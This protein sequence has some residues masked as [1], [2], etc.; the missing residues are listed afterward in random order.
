[1]ALIGASSLIGWPMATSHAMS[2]AVLG[3]GAAVRPKGVRWGTAAEIAL[4]WIFTI[5]AAG[6][7]AALLFG[8]LRKGF[9]VV[10]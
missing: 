1:M 2:S 7:M 3:A 9:H 10:P 8:L 6:F 5:P 4:A